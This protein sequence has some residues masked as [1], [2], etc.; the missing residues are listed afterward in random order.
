MVTVRDQKLISIDR[1]TKQSHLLSK[2]TFGEPFLAFCIAIA[3]AV[4]K[5]TPLSTQKEEEST[6]LVYVLISVWQGR[7]QSHV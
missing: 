7:I 6:L 1:P 3:T 5:F 4:Y 2:T